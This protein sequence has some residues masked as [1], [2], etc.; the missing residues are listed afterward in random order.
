MKMAL[1]FQEVVSSLK[2]LKLKSDDLTVHFFSDLVRLQNEKIKSKD[3]SLGE[4]LTTLR[5]DWHKSCL[6]VHVI[7]GKGL[8]VMDKTGKGWLEEEVMPYME[9]W[10]QVFLIS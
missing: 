9:E 4:L 1:N 7:Q 6:D 3:N 5:Y 10:P 8:P 2:T